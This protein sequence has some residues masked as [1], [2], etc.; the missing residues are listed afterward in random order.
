MPGVLCRLLFLICDK[1][2]RIACLQVRKRYKLCLER[3]RDK[4]VYRTAIAHIVHYFKIPKSA[5]THIRRK[6]QKLFMK[7]F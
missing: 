4:L 1:E 7:T 5:H 6:F 3:L 2:D